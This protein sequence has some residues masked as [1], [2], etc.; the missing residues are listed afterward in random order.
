MVLKEERTTCATQRGWVRDR[1]TGYPGTAIGP[2]ACR[3]N[4]SVLVDGSRLAATVRPIASP[5]VPST[6]DT[7]PMAR[8]RPRSVLDDVAALPWPVGLALAA[9]SWAV[10]RGVVPRF[11]SDNP[12]GAALISLAPSAAPF[13]AGL[14]GAAAAVSAARAHRRR[15]LVRGAEAGGSFQDMPWADFERAV[16]E[17]YRREGYRVTENGLGGADGG[18]DLV[19]ERAGER[20]LVQCKRWRRPC[21]VGPVRELAGVLALQHGATGVLACPGGFTDAAR[22]FSGQAGIELLDDGALLRRSKR[23]SPGTVPTPAP[24]PKPGRSS[25]A[26]TAG[27]TPGCPGC[28]ARMVERTAR[29]GPRAGTRFFGCSTF[30]ACRTTVSP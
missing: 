27:A 20:L 29:R 7:T 3:A 12:L 19:V 17:L 28:G 22:R 24:V 21:G 23:T 30:P 5:P 13:V 26:G 8:R 1:H 25:D 15:R 4:D 14:V 16:G 9:T 6:E 18:V 11:S 2:R 10:L